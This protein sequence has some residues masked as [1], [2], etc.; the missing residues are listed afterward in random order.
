MTTVPTHL[1]VYGTLQ[2]RRE[3]W[4]ELARFVTD[5]G[6]RATVVGILYD[7]GQGYP[8]AEFGRGPDA[9]IVH[10]TIVQI[11]PHGREH[12]LAHLDRY[13]GP[14]YRR[15]VVEAST[16]D[17]T[18]RAYT[19]EWIGPRRSLRRIDDGMWPND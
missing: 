12:G 2:P 14:G 17:A 5:A 3:A 11:T 19:Y 1:F 10:G 6:Q 18:H 7:T 8:A 9:G 15:I 16:S 4:G 13:E